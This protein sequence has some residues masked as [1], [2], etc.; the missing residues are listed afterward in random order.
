V[1]TYNYANEPT[2]V[3]F[4]GQTTDYTYG[5]GAIRQTKTVDGVTTFYTS[6]AEIRNFGTASEQI[7]LQP[8][9]DF[10]ITDAGGASEAVSYLHRDHLASVRLITNAAG[11]S[12]QSNTYTPFGDPDTTPLLATAIPEEHSFIG[13]RFDSSTGLLFLN[14]RYY[15][16]LLGRFLQPDWWEVRRPGVGTNR[17]SYSFND[18]VNLSDRNGNIV[19]LLLGA[20]AVGAL[21][22]SA[23][24]A[25]APGANDEIVTQS[26][27]HTLGNMVIGA[28]GTG[29]AVKATGAVIGAGTRACLANGTCRTAT[30]VT[31]ITDNLAGCVDGPCSVS[32]MSLRPSARQSELDTAAG[33]GP[34]AR[35]QVS[36][37][38]GVEVPYGTRGSSR[39][40]I[41]VGCAAC[42]EVKNYDLSNGPSGLIS[43]VVAQARG[44]VGN[45]PEGMA[46]RVRIDIRGQDVTDLMRI[47]IRSR[48]ILRSNGIID[49]VEFMQ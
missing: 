37:Q 40:D 38:R 29:L 20:A 48:I 3:V 16:P 25:N 10:R 19:P 17:F 47:Q 49:S 2:Q 11:V 14:A 33:L 9:A 24:P 43:N 13:E 45:L 28:T 8:H 30:G 42:Y 1:I 39:P 35:G 6:I 21:F 44:R 22:S 18:P 15:D 27:G 31:A 26:T 23:K 46:Q 7:I 12:E 41:V 34:G 32:G 5:P 36:F 4:A